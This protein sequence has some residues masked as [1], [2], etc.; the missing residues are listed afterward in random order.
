MIIQCDFDGTIIRNN[1]SV[2][3]REHFA[4][5]AWRAIEADYLEGKRELREPVG[6]LYHLWLEWLLPPQYYAL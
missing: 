5:D 1:L 6:N 2:L 3:I 4:P